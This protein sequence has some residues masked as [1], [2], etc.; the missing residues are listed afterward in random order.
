MHEER[1]PVAIIMGSQSDWE[2]MKN[3]AD[4]LDVLDV[5]YEARIV[6][7]HRTPERMFEFARQARDE[8]F[9]VI[10]A[11]AGGAAHLPGMTAAMT[12]LP[13]FGVPVQSKTMSG[14]DSLLS[15]VQM[16]A[17]IPVGTL[18]IGKAGA[19]NAA[20]LAAAVLALSDENLAG[21]LDDWRA[22]QTASVAEYPIDEAP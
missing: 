22:R 15:I 3:A 13:V 9:K 5:G 10:I 16:P 12:P 7:A 17:G 14:Q 1:P 6:S 18:A 4:T 2:T 21:R 11:G 19:I 8:G 20:L